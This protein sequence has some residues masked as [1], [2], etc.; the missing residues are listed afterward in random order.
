LDIA[1]ECKTGQIND[2]KDLAV[3]DRKK[4][5][6]SMTM[7]EVNE[8]KLEKIDSFF[9]EQNIES[10]N[11]HMMN[12]KDSMPMDILDQMILGLKQQDSLAPLQDKFYPALKQTPEQ[13]YYKPSKLQI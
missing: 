13:A 3:Q 1:K 12:R 7:A 10:K 2:P 4:K 8:S 6:T 11:N 5:I 9:H